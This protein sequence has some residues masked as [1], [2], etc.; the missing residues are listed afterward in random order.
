MSSSPPESTDPAAPTPGA[1]RS[2]P[3]DSY[4]GFAVLVPVAIAILVLVAIVFR[5]QLGFGSTEDA[6][7]GELVALP[8][9]VHV[10]EGSLG[11]NPPLTPAGGPHYD[12]PLRQGIYAEPVPDGNAIHSLEHGLVWITYRPEDIK[13][14]Q[15]AALEAVASDFARDVILSPR[16]ENASPVIVVSWG[17]RLTMDD[18]DAD[19]LQKFVTTNRNQSPEPGLR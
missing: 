12:Q 7:V 19:L 3:F 5:S 18:V 14:D 1:S 13:A 17:R 16:L 6:S 9:T 4:G 11:P 2:R 15:L 8:E 10:P